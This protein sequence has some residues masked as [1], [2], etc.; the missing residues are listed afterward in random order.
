MTQN[1]DSRINSQTL[2]MRELLANHCLRSMLA[3]A[4]TVAYFE[5]KT[6]KEGEEEEGGRRKEEET[7]QEWQRRQ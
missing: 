1:A 3:T 6:I 4:L 5:V 7:G 2:Q